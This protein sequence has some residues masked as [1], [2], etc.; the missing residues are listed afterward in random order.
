MKN[1]KYFYIICLFLVFT[2]CSD[3]LDQVPD[4][5]LTEENLFKSKDDVVKVLTQIYS[6]YNNPIDFRY[7]VGNAGDDVDFNWSG[8]NPYYKDLGSFGPANGIYENN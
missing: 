5:K 1:Y 6:T 3:Y 8:Y 7:Y 2:S 4:E